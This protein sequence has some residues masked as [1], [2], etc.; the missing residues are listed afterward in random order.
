MDEKTKKAN[1][2]RLAES[3]TQKIIKSIETLGNLS[4][5][6]N[7]EYSD[8]QVDRIFNTIEEELRIQKAKFKRGGKTKFRL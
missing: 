6:S 1:F 8:E 3:R 2:K 5:R 4:N 7:Y